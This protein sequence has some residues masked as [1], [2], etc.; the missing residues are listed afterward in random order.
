MK[1][2]TPNVEQL[3]LG[4]DKR[5]CVDERR[6]KTEER[7]QK[8]ITIYSKLAYGV[9]LPFGRGSKKSVHNYFERRQIT[10]SCLLEFAVSV[11]FHT[12]T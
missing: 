9:S 1:A 10:I 5:N 3:T 11:L 7:C 2:R 8:M 4:T 6:E 12:N